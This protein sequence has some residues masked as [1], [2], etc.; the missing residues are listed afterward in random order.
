MWGIKG[1]WGGFGLDFVHREQ[2]AQLG[3]GQYLIQFQRFRFLGNTGA[4]E[5]HTGLGTGDSLAMRA[6]TTIGEAMRAI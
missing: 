6:V 1:G 3:E 2:L 4:N 5:Y